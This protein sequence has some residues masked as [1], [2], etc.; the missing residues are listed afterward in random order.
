MIGNDC[1]AGIIVIAATL[2]YEESPTAGVSNNT[3]PVPASV[4]SNRPVKS[5]GLNKISPE[6]GE[7]RNN[8]LKIVSCSFQA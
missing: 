4:G 5:D 2:F 7:S 1:H 3:E 8:Y 6:V